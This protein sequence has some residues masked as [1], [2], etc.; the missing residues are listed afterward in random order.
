MVPRAAIIPPKFGIGE[1]LMSPGA[2][3][4]GPSFDDQ[5]LE[6]EPMPYHVGM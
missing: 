6:P 1:E 4:P 5:P 3:P 2:N